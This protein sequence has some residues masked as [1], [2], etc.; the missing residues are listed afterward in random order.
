MGDC[1]GEE[2]KPLL[3][4][5]IPLGLTGVF[6]VPVEAAIEIVHY[7]DGG[8]LQVSSVVYRAADTSRRLLKHTSK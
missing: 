8:Y 4:T 6:R 5:L 1:H 3:L 7:T 2:S